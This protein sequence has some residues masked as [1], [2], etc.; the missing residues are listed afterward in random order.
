VNDQ[1][2]SV[3]ALA[4]TGAYHRGLLGPVLPSPSPAPAPTPPPAAP[5]ARAD[6][7]TPPHLRPSAPAVPGHER[8]TSPPLRDLTENEARLA[9]E[10]GMT[11]EAFLS[12]IDVPADQVVHSKIGRPAS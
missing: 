5:A 9:R 12:W 4:A 6:M 10:R 3:A 8:P 7:A 2:L 11:K 1:L